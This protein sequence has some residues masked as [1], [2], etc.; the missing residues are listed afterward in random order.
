MIIID[1]AIPCIFHMENR[2]GEKI[3]KLILIE[4]MIER[5]SDKKSRKI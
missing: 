1:Q 2:V 4:G 3:L 5:D